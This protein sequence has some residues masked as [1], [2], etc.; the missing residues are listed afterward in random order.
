MPRGTR[1]IRIAAPATLTTIAAH[2]LQ[3]Q[4]ERDVAAGEHGDALVYHNRTW[5]RLGDHSRLV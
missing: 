4:L 1:G 2:A 5:H 3:A